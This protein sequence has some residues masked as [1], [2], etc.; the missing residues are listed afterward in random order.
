MLLATLR[1]MHSAADE[2]PAAPIGST[3]VQRLEH[4]RL[5]PAPLPQAT[6]LCRND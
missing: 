5:K 4:V 1:R 2:V 3:V 6:V